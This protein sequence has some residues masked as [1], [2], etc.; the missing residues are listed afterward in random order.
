[1]V[2]SRP[3]R[4]D[5]AHGSWLPTQHQVSIIKKSGKGLMSPCALNEELWTA[6]GF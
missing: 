2:S 6:D 3:D 4:P 1:M 5:G